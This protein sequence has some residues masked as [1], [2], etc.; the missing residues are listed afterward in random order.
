[1]ELTRGVLEDN[2]NVLFG[3]HHIEQ[4]YN[5]RMFERL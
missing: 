1:M 2:A 3:F 4:L 5:V